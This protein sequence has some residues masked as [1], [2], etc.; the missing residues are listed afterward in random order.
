MAPKKK[1]S[2]PRDEQEWARIFIRDM[3]SL[4][5]DQE[6]TLRADD[7]GERRHHGLRSRS[8]GFMS[9]T[10]VIAS[11]EGQAVVTTSTTKTM[12]DDAAG[13]VPGARCGRR[14]SSTDHLAWTRIQETPAT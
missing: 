7:L 1:V 13:G 11:C 12:T 8:G 5:T 9:I 3:Q 2:Q 6:D 4:E 14:P 10:D